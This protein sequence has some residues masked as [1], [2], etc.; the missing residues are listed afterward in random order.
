MLHDAGAGF[1]DARAAFQQVAQRHRAVH[2]SAGMVIELLE[3]FLFARHQCL[4]KL[5]HDDPRFAGTACYGVP[6]PV[7]RAP[8]P[9]K[10]PMNTND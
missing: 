10:N 9:T 7:K 8:G 4:E 2:Q 6:A 5:Q 1:R 3:E